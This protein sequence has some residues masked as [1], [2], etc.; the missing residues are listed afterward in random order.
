MH[1]APVG[2]LSCPYDKS[3]T[4][5]AERL[6]FHIMKCAKSHP[7]LA[8]AFVKCKFNVTHLLLGSDISKHENETCPDRFKFQNR[9][10]PPQEV[11]RLESEKEYEDESDKTRK[12]VTVTICELKPEELK[13]EVKQESNFFS[14]YNRIN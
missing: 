10:L 7:E 3:H 1:D 13:I 4:F 6:Q 11:K 2:W 12:N 14:V 8:A 9:Y 5:P